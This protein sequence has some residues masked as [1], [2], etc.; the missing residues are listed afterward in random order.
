MINP[1]TATASKPAVRDT[2]LFTPDAIPARL[3]CTAFIT[4]VVS[5]ATLIAMPKPSTMIAGRKVV[6]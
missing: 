5:G 6:Q 1:N 2:A 4:V 3:S